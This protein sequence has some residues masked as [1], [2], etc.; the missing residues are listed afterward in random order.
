MT[1]PVQAAAAAPIGEAEAFEIAEEAYTY[2]YPLVLMEL[3]R[4]VATNVARP[5]HPSQRAPVNQ[6]AHGVRVT[7]ARHRDV[8]RPN[9][10]T[11][12]SLLWYDVSHEPLVVTLPDTQ[13]RYFVFPLM[14]MWTDVYASLGTRTTGP[15]PGEFAIVAPGWQGE[16]PAGVRRIV[17]PTPEGWLVG[18]LQANGEADF[19]RVQGFQATSSAVPLSAYSRPYQPPA[20]RVDPGV[21]MRTPPATQIEQLSPAEFF[22]LFAELLKRH[23]PHAADYAVLLRMERLGLVAG[24]SFE[25]ARADPVARRA[26][27]R[28]VSEGVQG[29]LQR[30]RNLRFTRN[31]WGLFEGKMGIFGSDYLLRAFVAYRGLAGLPP[32]EA[33]YPSTLVDADGRPL[34]GARHRYVLH[35]EKGQTPPANAFW[36]LTMYGEDQFLVDNPIDR[37]AI[38]DRDK[39]SFNAD[40]SLDLYIQHE[41]PGQD[42]EANWLPAPAG[43]FSMNLRLYLPRPEA[44]DRRWW[45]EAVRRV[46]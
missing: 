13:G 6:F 24:Q 21:D 4:R 43:L 3:T 22:A 41:S 46:D 25:L 18:R 16:L 29:I 39:L 26:L 27:T 12:F 44:T 17:S 32:E 2:A 9:A 7:T 23:P 11:L 42:K 15:V 14:D 33:L 35:F 36:S 45:P 31:G 30:G 37:Y 20:G 34:D 5:D 40:G 1:T 8:V 10:D 28:A 19:P 38:G